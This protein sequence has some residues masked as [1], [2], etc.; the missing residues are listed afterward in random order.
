MYGNAL[1]Q[2]SVTV[3]AAGGTDADCATIKRD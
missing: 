1:V 3:Y 2:N